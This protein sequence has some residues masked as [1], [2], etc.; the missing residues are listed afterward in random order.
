MSSYQQLT[1]ALTEAYSLRELSAKLELHYGYKC[2]AAALCRWFQKQNIPAEPASYLAAILESSN[3]IVFPKHD[4]PR[5]E[6][7]AVWC[8]FLKP[9]LRT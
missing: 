9:Y 1:Y 7:L 8:Q 5:H 6:T 3:D 4:F 2:S